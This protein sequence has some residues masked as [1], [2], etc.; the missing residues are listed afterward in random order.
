MSWDQMIVPLGFIFDSLDPQK[1][2]TKNQ[3]QYQTQDLR[4][5]ITHLREI[6]SHRHRET[7]PVELQSQKHPA[8][9]HDSGDEEDPHAERARLPLL[10]HVL[11]MVLQRRVAVGFRCRGVATHLKY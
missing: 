8:K 10:L 4:P 9:K 7:Q 1:S 5:T 11:K 3:R 2:Q 6:D